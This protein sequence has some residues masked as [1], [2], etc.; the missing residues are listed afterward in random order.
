MNLLKHED[1]TCK[2]THPS[3]LNGSSH[4]LEDSFKRDRLLRSR[5]LSRHA[6]LPRGGVLSDDSNDGCSGD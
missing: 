1:L 6:T 3:A 2:S 5:Y 4:F